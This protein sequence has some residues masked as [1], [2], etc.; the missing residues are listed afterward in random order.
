MIWWILSAGAAV[1]LLMYWGSRNA[2]WGIATFGALVGLVIAVFT[3]F[4]WSIVVKAG[5]IG[6]FA[7]LAFEWLPR[8][9]PR[10]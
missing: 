4:G 9:L 2:V 10:S 3:G 6:T 7:G 1:V 5:V 8:L